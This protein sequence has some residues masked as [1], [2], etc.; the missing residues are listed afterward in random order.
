MNSFINHVECIVMPRNS[1]DWLKY[2]DL[3]EKEHFKLALE[4]NEITTVLQNSNYQI[5]DVW[6]NRILA[7]RKRV[8][9]FT[10]KLNEHLEAEE[11]I[12]LPAME[13]FCNTEHTFPSVRFSSMLMEQHFY[14]G[15]KYLQQFNELS[16]ILNEPLSKQE[17]DEIFNHLRKGIILLAEY[18]KVERQFILK[19]AEQMIRDM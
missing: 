11:K 13:L 1:S 2:V 14:S 7:L 12:L 5:M 16:N 19:Q 6:E 9:D 10:L 4:W 17:A 15:C 8:Q 18:F 3:L